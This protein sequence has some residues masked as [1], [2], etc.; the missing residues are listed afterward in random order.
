MGTHNPLISIIIPVYNAEKYLSELMDDILNQTYRKFE[1]IIVNDGSTDRSLAIV[2]KYAKKDKRI[3]IINQK[4]CGVSK[5][6][7]IGIDNASGEYVRFVD[8]DDRIPKH[9]ME[10]LLAPFLKYPELDLTIGNFIPEPTTPIF[11]GDMENGKVVSGKELAEQ[12]VKRPRTYYYGVLW[13]KMYRL[14]LIQK[15][16]IRF[17]NQLAWCED[18]LFNIKYYVLVNKICFV[19][20]EQSVYRYRIKVED[21]LT[22]RIE[23][24]KKGYEKIEQDRYKLLYDYFSTYNLEKTF[25]IEWENVNFYYRITDLVKKQGKSDSI[26][27]RYGR[28]LQV[29]ARDD[30]YTYLFNKKKSYGRIVRFILIFGIKHKLHHLLFTFFVLKGKFSNLL[31]KYS[32]KIKRILGIKIPP[33]Y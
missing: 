7:N 1:V 13:N 16:N 23:K 8:A 18:L 24:D 15:H 21:S 3:K 30:T 19:N 22:D 2:K 28:F 32:V 11:T 9:S 29:V 4:N 20:N 5:A 10:D 27:K 6:R 33:D 25:N 31:G 14:S 26:K 12:F 17:I